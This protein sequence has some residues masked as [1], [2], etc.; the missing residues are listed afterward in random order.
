MAG[1]FIVIEGPDCCGKGTLIES[2]KSHFGTED[3]LFVHDPGS[4]D[5]GE[6][7]REMLKY[8][9]NL[10]I[11]KESE[12]LL[13]TA[14]R[15]QLIHE[16]IFPALQND[17]NVFC[18]RFLPSTFVYQQ[19]SQGIFKDK[20]GVD[21]IFE[22]HERFC[23]KL[24]PDLCLVLD[25][26]YETYINRKMHSHRSNVEND[27]FESRENENYMREVI[28]RYIHLGGHN[29]VHIDAKNEAGDV[30]TKAL[31]AINDRLADRN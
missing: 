2:L 23:N 4:T 20:P 1:K 25:I 7:L 30:F 17:M 13:F 28:Y 14:A 3:S 27:R 18:D 10:N 16:K 31:K 5:L 9:K 15:A 12:L 6:K 8:G 19:I 22:L 26:D 24:F 29:V 11:C 21:L